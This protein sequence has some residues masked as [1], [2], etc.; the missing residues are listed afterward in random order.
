V[1]FHS[2]LYDRP[3]YR[4]EIDGRPAPD[5]LPDLNLDQLRDALERGRAEY[6][7]GPVFHAP[8]RTP[9]EV[10]Y[11]QAI[12]R[13]L[14]DDAVRAA[15]ER[16]AAGM[17]KAREHLALAGKLRERYQKRRW[18]L[19]AAAAYRDAVRDLAAGLGALEPRSAGL[20]GFRAHVAA[21]AAAEPFTAFAAAIDARY[22]DLDSV[23]YTVHIKGPRVR[24]GRYDGEHDYGADVTAT[25]GKFAQ[26]TVDGVDNPTTVGGVGNP[27]EVKDYRAAFGE[28]ADMN[29][30]DAQVLALVARLFPEVFDA[31]DAFCDR[32]AGLV[33]DTI[34]AFDR[35]VRFYLAYL[36][37]IA[38]LK[39]AGLDFCYPEV[40]AGPGP[41][42][43]DASFDL[44]LAHKPRRERAPVVTNGFRLDPPER[45]LVVTGPNQ[46]G[47]TTFA[48]MFGQLHHLAALGLPVP[49]ASVRLRLPDRVF[50][51]FERE[52][53]AESPRGKLE[54]ELVR[55]RAVLGEATEASV[56]VM[57][58][59]F[60]STTLHDAL[61]LGTEILG[62]VTALGALCVYV[63]FVDELAAL[64][65][66]TVSMVAAITPGDPASRTFR[67]ERRP[68][69]GLAYAAAIADTYGL[70]YEALKRRLAR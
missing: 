3:D 54:D 27:A 7:L 64:N 62:R 42:H 34:G 60:T 2:V 63:T 66:A 41:V 1:E 19:A 37:L 50:T 4:T 46:G 11:R 45:V 70:S 61:F 43:A 69:D 17:R 68:A 36:E 31:L 52:E 33:D 13:D 58:E 15:V 47:K 51:H 44:V 39:E 23:A 10:A 24:V 28:H 12:V 38:P 49:G 48:R 6:G 67:I 53:D 8:L 26:G 29:H 55:V 40:A 14:E 57:N 56:L 9:A 18:F 35:E 59:S 16:F 25:F 32:Y 65:D 22:A 21:H 20:R 30:V 5:Y